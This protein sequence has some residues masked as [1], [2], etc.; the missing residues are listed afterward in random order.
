MGSSWSVYTRSQ[1][2][3]NSSPGDVAGGRSDQEEASRTSPGLPT[4]EVRGGRGKA[5]AEKWV[6]AGMAC[7]PYA[8]TP[9]INTVRTNGILV[10]SGVSKTRTQRKHRRSHRRSETTY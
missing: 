10:G 9:Q 7:F 1:A 5:E 4:R 6:P 3:R 2:W 8:R